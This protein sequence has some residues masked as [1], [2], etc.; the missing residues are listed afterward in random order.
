MGEVPDEIIA[1]RDMR[2][3]YAGAMADAP[4]VLD[5]PE[6]IDCSGRW[7]TPG[8]IDYHTHLIYAGDRSHEFRLRLRG[9]GL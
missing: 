7:I 3:V 1:C 4:P 9:A 8:L 6:C 2:I 5:A